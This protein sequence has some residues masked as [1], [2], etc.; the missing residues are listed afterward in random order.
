MNQKS[1]VIFN[2]A[3]ILNIH[4]NKIVHNK[5]PELNL[6]N[7]LFM[8]LVISPKIKEKFESILLLLSVFTRLLN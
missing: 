5:S 2:F 6:L 1:P 7:K 8:L 4:L 3:L